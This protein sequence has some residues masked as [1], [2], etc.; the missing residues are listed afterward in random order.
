[1]P[2]F[3]LSVKKGTS[4][5]S[6]PPVEFS[7]EQEGDEINIIANGSLIA[8]FREL[9]G[10]ILLNSCLDDEDCKVFA[11]DSKGVLLVR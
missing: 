3:N 4:L 2:K 7:L 8:Y 5:N 9:D 10:K 1:M 11:H 6:T